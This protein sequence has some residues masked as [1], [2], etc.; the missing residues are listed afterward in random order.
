MQSP[1]ILCCSSNSLS[2]SFHFPISPPSALVTGNPTIS[3]P[4]FS[5]S[6]KLPF[7]SSLPTRPI[8]RFAIQSSV[9]AAEELVE[10]TSSASTLIETG[11]IFGVHGFHGEVRVKTSTDF[12]DLRFSK[13]GT[14]W[15]KQQV[16]G[17]ET[18]QEIELVE[19]RGHPGQSWIV[20]FNNI[21]TS[22][23]AQKL[24]G[25]TILVTDEDRPILEEGE[26]YT[27]DLI[28]MKLIL[29]ESGEPVGTVVNVFNSGANDLLRVKLNSSRS[30]TEQ[31]GKSETGSGDSGPLIWVPFV[32]AIVPTVDLEKR[33]MLI[34][35]PKGLLELN[36][37][38]DDR[39]KKERRELEW[40]ERKKLQRR[41]IAAKKKL[42]EMEQQHVFHGLRY[43]EKDQRSLLADQIVTLN[44]KLLQHAMQNIA[45]P[46]TRPNLLD[47]LNDVPRSNTLR[48]SNSTSST[49]TGKVSDSSLKVQK[50]G[51]L[52]TC[53]GKVALV[54]VL[55]DIEIE[56]TSEENENAYLLVKAL[57]DNHR[58]SAKIEDRSIVP[59]ILVSSAGAVSSLQNLFLEHDYLGFDPEKVWFLEEEKL[60][61]VSSLLDVQGKHKILM[62]S[63]WE[64]LRRPIGSGGVITL[65]SSH[66]S[67]LDQLSE[68]GVEYIEISKINKSREDEYSLVGLVESCK[69]NM[70]IRLF[71]DMS[72]EEDFEVVFSMSFL[73]KLVKQT[74][75]L[76]F[77]A[78][79]SCSSY[80]EL[81]EK[82]W[83]DVVPT[84]PNCYEFCSSIYWCLDATPVNKV[85]V[86]DA[87]D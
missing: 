33:E 67:L 80:V 53:K 32:E 38:S 12:P 45:I 10:A 37:R 78:V 60:P 39:T 75:K 30:T 11:Y 56:K 15:L 65:L 46:S 8:S 27:Q 26:F 23:Q 54:L 72:S 35:P 24:V 81:V 59:L 57:L 28:G 52:L 41:L 7:F 17:T 66:E 55:D 79:L 3:A 69:S 4:N 87:T 63:P 5:H 36:I 20:R 18:L 21:D 9:S 16:S 1:S 58:S 73:R 31:I 49:G 34:T 70:G 84:S 14:R 74:N 62:K 61:L 43:G 22:E 68:T 51:W 50:E 25:S 19:G 71:K 82:D 86:L 76:Q 42:V 40:K 13:P 29:K 2:L 47:I 83:V 64:F 48:V 77:R 6:S 85:C 44:S